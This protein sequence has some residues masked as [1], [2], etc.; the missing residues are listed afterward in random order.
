[1]FAIVTGLDKIKPESKNVVWREM[2]EKLTTILRI[3]PTRVSEVRNFTVEDKNEDGTLKVDKE[4][5]KFILRAMIGIL[6]PDQMPWWK[7]QE[8][9]ATASAH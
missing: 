4:Q 7:S 9:T 2:E 8:T 5:R 3:P 6:S 1:M